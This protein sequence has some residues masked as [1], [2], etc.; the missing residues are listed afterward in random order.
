MYGLEA[1]ALDLR[2][3]SAGI[4]RHADQ[5]RVI[6]RQQHAP[7]GQ[8][9]KDEVDLNELGGVGEQADVGVDRTP[10]PRPAERRRHRTEQADDH[11]ATECEERDL[12]REPRAPEQVG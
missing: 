2:Q 8:R 9:K 7:V 12:Q 4:E 3:V 11:A 10:H 5:H 1:R 6:R